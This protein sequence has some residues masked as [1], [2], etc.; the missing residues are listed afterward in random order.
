MMREKHGDSEAISKNTYFLEQINENKE[1]ETQVCDKLW[2]RVA[3]CLI[4]G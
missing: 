2:S 4:L 1:Q 3:S